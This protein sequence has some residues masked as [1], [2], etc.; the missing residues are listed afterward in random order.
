MVV[1]DRTVAVQK[2]EVRVCL[3]RQRRVLAETECRQKSQA[4]AARLL[5]SDPFAA[6]RCVHCYVATP[7][8]VQTEAVI[9]EALRR[10]KRVVAPTMRGGM[11][12]L[13]EVKSGDPLHPG[14][15]GILEPASNL[16][17]TPEE[18][19]LWVVPGVGFGRDGSRLGRGGGY[20][21]RLLSE[22][23]GVVIGL[24]FD[25]QVADRMPTEPS[26]RFVDYV[27]TESAVI[28]CRAQA[29]PRVTVGA[30]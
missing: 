22:A 23:Q 21:D 7:T 25:F 11:P 28:P 13:S 27:M 5:A 2:G 30:S 10:G 24:A 1:Q 3:L 12:A 15:F 20:Y 16:P 29:D 18:V 19:D 8:E 4:V 26:D 14:A 6:A 17:V 9:E